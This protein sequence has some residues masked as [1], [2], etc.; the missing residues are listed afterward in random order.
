MP[1]QW[2]RSERKYQELLCVVDAHDSLMSEDSWSPS[3]HRRGN[4]G[5]H[6]ASIS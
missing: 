5:L 6:M 3:F 4:G 1:V 2:V